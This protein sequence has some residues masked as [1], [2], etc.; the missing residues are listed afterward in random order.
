VKS[1]LL[2]LFSVYRNTEIFTYLSFGILSKI[3]PVIAGF[4]L[5]HLM[6]PSDYGIVAVFISII[7]LSASFINFGVN[8][9]VVRER[10]FLTVD[11]FSNLLTSSRILSLVLLLILVSSIT[12]IIYLSDSIIDWWL[13]ICAILLSYFYAF[14]D[15]SEKVFVA[16]KDAYGFGS[17]EIVKVAGMSIISIFFILVF[18]DYSLES[19]IAGIGVG[20]L[21]AT[22]YAIY[23]LKLHAVYVRP[24]VSTIN[25]IFFYGVK[26]LPQVISVW[27]KM[28]ADKILLV[29]IVSL[30]EIGAY[31]FT[32]TI[33]SMVMVV[34]SALN[35]IYASFSMQMYK[36]KKIDMLRKKRKMYILLSLVVFSLAAI[37]LI[38][39]S[40]IYWPE[41]YKV[42]DLTIVLIFASLFFQMVYLLFAKYNIFK[43][44]V[45]VLGL[46]NFLLTVV[47]V[48]FLFFPLITPTI[49]YVAIC[50]MLY[51][52]SL[53][54]WVV[55]SATICEYVDFSKKSLKSDS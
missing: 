48:L 31:S 14:I 53:M 49:E 6:S 24:S 9:M 46:I 28:G 45:A 38:L 27:V 52:F 30:E 18:S 40:K 5:T 50:F 26:V 17:L 55:V 47:Y 29:A 3:F 25:R 12:L 23:R 2:K 32:F 34:G 44:T 33:C 15:V 35:N 54:I 7:V 8:Q 16:T 43:E 4:I 21:L 42:S 1:K 36:E 13:V 51:N 10:Y 41:G 37:S 11:E 39:I 20:I 22:V 19:R